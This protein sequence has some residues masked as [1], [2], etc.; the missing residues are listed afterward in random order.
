MS[1]EALGS[2]DKKGAWG[3]EKDPEQ[4]CRVSAQTP[5]LTGIKVDLSDP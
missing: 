1:E 2:L 4:E 3:G 5:P